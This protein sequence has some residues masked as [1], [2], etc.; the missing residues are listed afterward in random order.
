MEGLPKHMS[1]FISASKKANEI[2]REHPK[3]YRGQSA[4][5]LIFAVPTFMLKSHGI[6]HPHAVYT[7]PQRDNYY[8]S[9][10]D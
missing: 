4:Q 2:T 5:L 1:D 7:K 9:L 6:T 3:G 10:I 8:D